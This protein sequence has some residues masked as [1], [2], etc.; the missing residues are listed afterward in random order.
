VTGPGG[1]TFSIA[2]LR[3]GLRVVVIRVANEPAEAIQ[4]EG[5]GG[6]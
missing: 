1:R 6:P 4:V 5:L 2:L 3:R